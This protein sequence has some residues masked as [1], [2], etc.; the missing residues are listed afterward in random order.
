MERLTEKLSR[1]AGV[2]GRATAKL[3]ERA[4]LLIARE[5]SID[6]RSAR[7]FEANHAVLDGG[8]KGLDEL[9]SKLALLS[10]DPLESSGSSPQ[11]VQPASQSAGSPAST[12]PRV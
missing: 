4:D 2:V 12:E 6:K 11:G 3:E 5:E 10:N 7:I 9:E 1:A 8:D